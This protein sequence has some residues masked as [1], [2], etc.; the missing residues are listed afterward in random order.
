MKKMI[1]L[2]FVLFN[3]NVN[4]AQNL[5]PNSDF[6]QKTNIEDVGGEVYYSFPHWTYISMNKSSLLGIENTPYFD[7]QEYLK[8]Y[9]KNLRYYRKYYYQQFFYP[10]KITFLVPK[11]DNNGEIVMDGNTVVT[12]DEF[13]VDTTHSMYIPNNGNSY[14][15]TQKSFIIN[16]FQVKLINAIEKDKEYYFEMYYRIPY[17]IL[18]KEDLNKDCFGL[19]FSNTDN[20]TES[21]R[22]HFFSRNNK[23]TPHVVFVNIDYTAS[24]EW[25]KFSCVFK[26]DDTYSYMIIGNHKPFNSYDQNYKKT[27][28]PNN[29]ITIYIDDL[30]LIPY[31]K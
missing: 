9:E 29:R 19:Y 17:C 7:F 21:N 4:N 16:L 28:I 31:T 3:V 25:I 5:I 1:L 18:K 12:V 27:R 30:L 26:A 13:D 2:A 15:R 23:Y 6:E 11:R 22:K 10:N 24:D 8:N 14:L 20:S